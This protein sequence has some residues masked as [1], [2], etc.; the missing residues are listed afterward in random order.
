[1]WRPSQEERAEGDG[2]WGGGR[3]CEGG[4]NLS[5]EGD[6]QQRENRVR[7]RLHEG[8]GDVRNEREE[9]SQLSQD[10]MYCLVR[11]DKVLLN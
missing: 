10:N 2:E 8:G 6:P 5:G 3:N 7:H 11:V 1:V 4:R 9:V